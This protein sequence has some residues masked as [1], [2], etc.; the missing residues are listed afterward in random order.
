GL[1]AKAVARV[2]E[3]EEKLA[4]KTTRLYHGGICPIEE[5]RWFTS[6]KGYAEEDAARSGGV[7]PCVDIPTDQPLIGPEWPDPSNARGFTW[8]G[9]LPAEWATQARPMPEPV[10]ATPPKTAMVDDPLARARHRAKEA[11]PRRGKERGGPEFG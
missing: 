8:M 10:K 1:E 9:E 7:V 3:L 11:S 4:G 5:A 2:T 6:S